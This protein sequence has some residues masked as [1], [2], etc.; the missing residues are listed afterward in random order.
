[1]KEVGG[2][3]KDRRER[4]ETGRKGCELLV[5]EG[6]GQR[7]GKKERKRRR[8]QLRKFH[9]VD[10]IEDASQQEIRLVR[11]G[12]RAKDRIIISAGSY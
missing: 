10:E 1:V 6:R 4:R 12:G 5:Q 3:N 8:G 11:G 9:Q 7:E 2:R